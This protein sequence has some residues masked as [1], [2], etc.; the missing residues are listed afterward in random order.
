MDNDGCLTT[1]IIGPPVNPSNLMPKADA[2]RAESRY[3]S[4]MGYMKGDHIKLQEISLGYTLKKVNLKA[5]NIS[6]LRAYAQ[7]KN[8]LYLYKAA[9]YDIYPEA[10]NLDLNIPRTFIFGLNVNF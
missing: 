2:G 4:A 1:T 9:K 10:S 8:V 6:G 3:T 5:F 7:M